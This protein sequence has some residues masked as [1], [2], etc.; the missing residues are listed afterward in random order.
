MRRFHVLRKE[1]VSGVSGVGYVAE[2]IQFTNKQIIIHWI[3]NPEL[4]SIA[5]Y[6]NINNFLKIHGHE[7]KTCI[8]WVDGYDEKED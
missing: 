7:N 5:I 2:G 4:S 3:A 6:E 1:D 8:N